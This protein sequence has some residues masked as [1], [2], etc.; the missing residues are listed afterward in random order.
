MKDAVKTEGGQVSPNNWHRDMKKSVLKL[1]V[2][3]VLCGCLI[4]VQY[5]KKIP[6]N[7]N[8]CLKQNIKL[9]LK[10]KTKQTKKNVSTG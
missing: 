10:I 7:A 2:K 1:N 9:N 8:G 4:K 3:F 5:N 6:H